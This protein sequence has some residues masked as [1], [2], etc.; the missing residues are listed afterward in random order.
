MISMKS[1]LLRSL[2]LAALALYPLRGLPCEPE[3]IEVNEPY[4]A[5]DATLEEWLERLEDGWIPLS[6]VEAVLEEADL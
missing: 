6:L 1:Y 3:P 2:F 4:D 5:T